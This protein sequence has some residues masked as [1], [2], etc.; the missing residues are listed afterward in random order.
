MSQHLQNWLPEIFF[1]SFNFSR[2]F[3]HFYFI[4]AYNKWM[5]VSDVKNLIIILTNNAYLPRISMYLQLQYNYI[6]V[7]VVTVCTYI[8]MYLYLYAYQCTHTYGHMK[9]GF[10]WC[11]LCPNTPPLWPSYPPAVATGIP[12]TLPYC[13][14]LHIHLSI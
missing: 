4:F 13:L 14:P 7:L 11:P 3:K 10:A 8:C 6:F 1:F 12:F 5:V 9:F 2:H